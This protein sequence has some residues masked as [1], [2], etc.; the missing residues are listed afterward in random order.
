MADWLLE[1]ALRAIREEDPDSASWCADKLAEN[2]ATDRLGALRFICNS[3]DREN[4]RVVAKAIGVSQEDL[5]ACARVLRA[6]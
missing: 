1:T 6:I 3:L 2:S 4:Q 5:D